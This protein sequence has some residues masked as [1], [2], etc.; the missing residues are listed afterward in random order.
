MGSCVYTSLEVPGSWDSQQC[1]PR[2]PKAV[3]TVPVL[4]VHTKQPLPGPL[5]GRAYICLRDLFC[6][7]K[8]LPE[9]SSK[10]GLRVHYLS[11]TACDHSLSSRR[12]P[13]LLWGGQLGKWNTHKRLNPQPFCSHND[14]AL[15]AN[16]S[17]QAISCCQDRAVSLRPLLWLCSPFALTPAKGECSVFLLIVPVM[18]PFADISWHLSVLFMEHSINLKLSAVSRIFKSLPDL[19]FKVCI[20]FIHFRMFEGHFK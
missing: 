9:P 6:I 2:Y 5:C 18:G 4:P 10:L 17:S 7:N 19:K 16:Q 11:A 12:A 1:Y 13:C 8:R 3:I 14:F 20:D 15:F